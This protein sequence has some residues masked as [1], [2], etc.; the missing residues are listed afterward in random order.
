MQISQ[1]K[2][3]WALGHAYALEMHVQDLQSGLK[4]PGMK[5][6]VKRDSYYYKLT[7]QTWTRPNVYS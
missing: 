7:Q 5:A 3:K 1:A 6:N 2:D 4:S